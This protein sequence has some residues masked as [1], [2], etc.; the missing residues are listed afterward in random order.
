M[1]ISS[2]S[3]EHPKQDLWDSLKAEESNKSKT[4]CRDQTE[5]DGFDHTFSVSGTIIISYDR[6]N[7]II[8]PEQWHKEE[9]LQFKVHTKNGCCG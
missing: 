7:S 9:T 4:E 8:Q 1:S 3:V 2:G 6:C 5:P